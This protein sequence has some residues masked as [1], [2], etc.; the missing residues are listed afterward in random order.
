M[1]RTLMALFVLGAAVAA[2][3][4]LGLGNSS[5]PTPPSARRLRAG[6]QARR[7][8]GY[9]SWSRRRPAREDDR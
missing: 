7:E 9:Q 8:G 5:S 3:S 6:D 4:A 2:F 1:L